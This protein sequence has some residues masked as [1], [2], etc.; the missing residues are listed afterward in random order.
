MRLNNLRISTW[1]FTLLSVFSVLLVGIDG[2]VALFLLDAQANQHHPTQRMTHAVDPV[3]TFAAP[4]AHAHQKR[5]GDRAAP[6]ALWLAT[7]L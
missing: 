5:K 7:P 4:M 2:T 6:A 1:L 3:R